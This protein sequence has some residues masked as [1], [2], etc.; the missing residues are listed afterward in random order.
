M[1]SQY[2]LAYNVGPRVGLYAPASGSPIIHA[3]VLSLSLIQA[4]SM[5]YSVDQCLTEEQDVRQYRRHVGALKSRL[6][7][8]L[9]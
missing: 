1:L 5:Q 7:Q 2:L 4:A 9:Q 3:R 6:S 8:S